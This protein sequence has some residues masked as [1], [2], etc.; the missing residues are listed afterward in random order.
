VHATDAE[1]EEQRRVLALIERRRQQEEEDRR[2]AQKLA[3]ESAGGSGNGSGGGRVGPL[4]PALVK[5][6]SVVS[7]VVGHG[8]LRT[9]GNADEDLALALKVRT[10]IHK[11]ALFFER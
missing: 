8:P 2:L 4:S 7:P 11:F 9:S 1:L 6:P 5:E 3:Q 10:Y